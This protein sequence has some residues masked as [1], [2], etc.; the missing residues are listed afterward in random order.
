MDKNK[1]FQTIIIIL[2][3][4]FGLALAS[5]IIP[6]IADIG[7]DIGK[8]VY[9]LF[10]FANLRPSHRG[11]DKFIELLAIAIFVGWTINRFKNKK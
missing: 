6:Q 10:R 2:C 5:A 1:I 9:D 3:C 8:H 11:F 7:A 4:I